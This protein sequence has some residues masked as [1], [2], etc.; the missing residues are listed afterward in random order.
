M[1]VRTFLFS[2]ANVLFYFSPGR[3]HTSDGLDDD[4]NSTFIK[5][6]ISRL[7]LNYF[8][9]LRFPGSCLCRRCGHEIVAADSL[10]RVTSKLAIMQRNDTILNV[11]N[12]L[13]QLFK[14]PAGTI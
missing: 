6:N 8:T 11:P 14:N 9:S 7:L 12:V 3:S 13:I 5:E 4:E 1:I 10:I 2:F